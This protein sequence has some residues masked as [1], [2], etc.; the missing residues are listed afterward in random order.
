MRDVHTRM[1]TPCTDGPHELCY[2][3]ILDAQNHT[4]G[5]I[6]VPGHLLPQLVDKPH[7]FLALA[8]STL[9]RVDD[10]P[11]WDPETKSFTHWTEQAIKPRTHDAPR[12]P[13]AAEVL[14]TGGKF[15]WERGEHE[16]DDEAFS[17]NL[18][19]PNDEFF[20][21]RFY[22]DQVYWPAMNVLLLS[23]EKDGVVERVGVGKIHVDAFEGVARGEEVWL[24]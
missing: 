15:N 11:S 6:I 24:G 20:D 4:A 21:N 16:D 3:A 18:P 8:R 22:S 10:D 1:K 9:S 14:P 5:T 2:L 13:R 23:D 12:S 7:R 17:R 19:P